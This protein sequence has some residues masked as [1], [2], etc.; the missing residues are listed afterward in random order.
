MSKEWEGQRRKDPDGLTFVFIVGSGGAAELGPGIEEESAVE[1][2][3]GGR[4]GLK[5]VGLLV[6]EERFGFVKRP[7]GPRTQPT[8]G[9]SMG[10]K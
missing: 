3:A 10:M 5:R 2:G 6:N 8:G 4:V 9:F 7:S 1:A